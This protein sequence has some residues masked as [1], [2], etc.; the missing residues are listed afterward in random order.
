MQSYANP[1]RLLEAQKSSRILET[2]TRNI[3]QLQVLMAAIDLLMTPRGVACC[4]SNMY[5][6]HAVLCAAWVCYTAQAQCRTLEA[7]R[8]VRTLGCGMGTDVRTCCGHPT[9]YCITAS[10]PANCS[11]AHKQPEWQSL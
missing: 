9:H 10:K 5:T 7:H 4:C 2:S 3:K 1:I 8:Q 11:A 6:E